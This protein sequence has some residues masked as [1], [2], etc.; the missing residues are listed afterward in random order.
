MLGRYCARNVLK[1]LFL[2][3]N[4]LAQQCKRKNFLLDV[5]D[6]IC[7]VVGGWA[8]ANGSAACAALLKTTRGKGALQA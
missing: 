3:I 6:I 1:T 5:Y 4:Y 7:V 2:F 8:A